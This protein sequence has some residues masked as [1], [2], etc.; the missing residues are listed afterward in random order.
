MRTRTCT[1]TCTCTCAMVRPASPRLASPRLA[2]PR[3]ASP[4]LASPRLASP[5]LALPCPRL[6]SP[7]L[8]SALPCP[9]PCPMPCTLPYPTLPC[10]A[11]RPTLPCTCPAHTIRPALALPCA[12]C[13]CRSPP[14]PRA[15]RPALRT[16]IQARPPVA[17]TP[18]LAHMF[19]LPSPGRASPTLPYTYTPALRPPCCT[20][21]APVRL[22]ATLC[23]PCTA[24]SPRAPPLGIHIYTM[25][26]A[27]AA[28]SPMVCHGVPWCAMVCIYICIHM[29]TLHHGIYICVP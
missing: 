24:A 22:R 11:P 4:R 7:R 5:R 3:L 26:C 17:R 19:A 29:Y 14:W 6:A 27:L 13:F 23:P 10:P 2:S 20:L 21:P 18:L 9:S 25:P 8:H 15:P 16:C 12:P 1:C 28:P